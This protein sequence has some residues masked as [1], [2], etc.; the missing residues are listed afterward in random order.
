[1]KPLGGPGWT[2][3]RGVAWLSVALFAAVLTADAPRAGQPVH[4]ERFIFSGHR[5][6]VHASSVIETPQRHLLA[7]WYENGEPRPDTFFQG[8]DS[9]KRDDVRIAGARL[10]RGE[11]EWSAPFVVSDTF[12]VSDN[13][14]ALAI[15]AQERLWLVHPTLL[16]VPERPWGSA[17]L[18]YKVSS[19]YEGAGPPKW[20]RERLLVAQPQ[21]LYEEVA[22][23]AE[24]LTRNA[25]RDNRADIA[26]AAGL[27]DALQDPFA[28]RLG[29]MPRTHPLVLPDGTLLVPLAN[30]NFNMAAMALTR[31]G[32]DTWQMSRVV[33]G[34]GVLQPSVVRLPSGRLTAFFRDATADRRIK[35]SDSDDG[36]MTWS[37]IEPTGLPNPGGGVEALVLRNGH[38]AMI[39]NDKESNP[40]DRLAV[41]ISIDEGRTWRWTRHLENR[42]GERFDYPSIIQARDGT[43]HA[44][45]SYNLTTIKHVHFDE[46]WVQQGDQDQ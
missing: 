31:D 40:R 44:T 15:D 36:G 13:N 24:R 11:R 2:T 43:L 18:W 29:W 16:A 26:R 23:A 27:L 28:R 20:D 3:R 45:Y 12:G 41:S 33:P 46:A 21:G 32:G 39:Y 19:D 30:E 4:T 17:V 34:R 25:G 9:D 37:P 1:M 5:E 42:P 38:L 14:P 10:A 8:T 35:R 7:V 22:R 6:H